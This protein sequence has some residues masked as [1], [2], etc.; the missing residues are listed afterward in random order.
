MADSSRT[1]EYYTGL[2][3]RT[4]LILETIAGQAPAEEVEKIE[5]AL[6]KLL[7]PVSYS[8]PGGAEVE[9]IKAYERACA[10]M[11]QH[12]SKDPKQMTVLEFYETLESLK[13]DKKKYELN[14]QPH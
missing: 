8:G 7:P 4:V 5:N 11:R 9:M 13:T 3:Q 2:K 12:Q 1:K 6:L 14:G 10:V